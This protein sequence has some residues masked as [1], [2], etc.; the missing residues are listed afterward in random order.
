MADPSQL[1]QVIVNLVTNAAQAIGDCPGAIVISVARIGDEALLSV[2]DT[3]NGMDEATRARIFEPFF[4]TKP[5]GEGRAL[6]WPWST[7]SSWD[8]AAGSTSAATRMPGRSSRWHCPLPKHTLPARKLK[9]RNSVILS[10]S[11]LKAAEQNHC[12]NV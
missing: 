12:C 11:L 3:G 7:G 5:V 9:I 2:A 1:Q 4:T 10:N 6:D 8:M